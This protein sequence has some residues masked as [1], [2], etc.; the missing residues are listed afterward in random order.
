[1]TKF[2]ITV[3]GITFSS[4]REAAAHFKQHYGSVARRIKSGWSYEEALGL[5]PH[6]I[7]RPSRGIKLTT[8]A[9]SFDSIRDAADHFGIKEGTIHQRLSLGWTPDQAV[10][11][12]EHR[13]N[14]RQT[15]EVTCAGKTYPNSWAMA[16]AYGKRE[17]LVAKRL[18]LGWT[19]EQA[20]ELEAAPPRFRNQKNGGTNPF[21]RQV[22]IVDEKEYPATE[23][24][25]YKLYLITNKVNGMQY[26]GITINPLW[27]RFSGHKRSAAKGTNTKLY[28]AIR[29]HGIEN[30]SIELL[31]S[32]ARSFAGLQQ[33]EV[34]E[35]EKRDTI[36][37]GY[38]VSP[39]GSIGTPTQITVGGM[40]FPSRG[41]AAD[42]FGID[43][44]VFNL[45]ISRLGWTPEQ[46]AEIEPRGKYS[47]NRIEAGGVTYP[48]IKKAAEAH[49][50]DYQLV[51]DRI[52]HIGW[53]I[54]QALGIAPAPE[55]VKYQGIEVTVFGN[56]FSTLSACATHYGISTDTLRRHMK[57]GL[58]VEDAL[59]VIQ[60]NKKRLG[61][62]RYSQRAA[63]EKARK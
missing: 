33:Q 32:D 5:K 59:L 42:Y 31:R 37:N 41:A 12:D 28:N 2:S 9:G 46:A 23:Q 6:R 27:Q 56:H 51:W 62:L 1:M 35:I 20:V 8:S 13:K 15:K 11:L 55:T 17:K 4:M 29:L 53:T 26:V 34:S 3:A 63:L 60:A 49:E 25:E 18:L 10:G 22:E 50:L 21:W 45:R 57:K 24:G 39:G 61:K 30:F 47:R 40:A 7:K 54:D 48:S 19:P 44:S 52:K 38:N 43:V 36:N 58:S 16:Q 14:P